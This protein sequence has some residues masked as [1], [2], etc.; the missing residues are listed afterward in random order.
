MGGDGVARLAQAPGRRRGGSTRPGRCR[1]R[2]RRARAASGRRVE[3][4]GAGVDLADRQL[5]GVGVAGGFGL[6]DPLDLARR[7]RG[8]RARRRRGPRARSSASSRRRRRRRGPRAGRR[9]PR[10]E[11]SGYVA[12]EDE[13]RLAV[14]RSAAAP[15]GRRR[16]SRRARAGRPI[17]TPSGSPA[18]MSLLGRDDCR[19][20]A[21][22]P[23]S[24]AARIGQATIGRPQTGCSIFGSEERMRVPS[25]A[26]MT[27]TRGELTAGS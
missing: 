21:R 12:G 1:W 16:R 27:R 2:G 9:S 24:R 23:A 11:S 15:R 19:R 26:A 7:G 3:G 14:L 6:D 18:E 22:R 10:R 25:P 17:S 8:P 4:V 13:H 20:R 5:L